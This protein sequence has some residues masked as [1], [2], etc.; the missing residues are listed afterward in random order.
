[1]ARELTKVTPHRYGNSSGLTNAWVHGAVLALSAALCSAPLHL[2]SAQL[3]AA[4]VALG[5][6]L[7]QHSLLWTLNADNQTLQIHE[8]FFRATLQEAAD[9]YAAEPPKVWC[10]KL[11]TLCLFCN[12]WMCNISAP[13]NNLVMPAARQGLS[14]LQGEITLLVQGAPAPEQ[15]TEQEVEG[16]L[17]EVLRQLLS[18]G[19]SLSDAAKQA[20]LQLNVRK[21]KAYHLALSIKGKV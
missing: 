7:W 1:M 17:Q 20:S 14:S 10:I 19:C 15:L 11:G 16:Q 2:H 12:H 5:T 9:R 18:S 21:S 8:E 3:H 4:L 6:Q 13:A